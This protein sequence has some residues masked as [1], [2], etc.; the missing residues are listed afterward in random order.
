MPYLDEEGNHLKKK[1]FSQFRGNLLFSS[2]N[3]MEFK[4]TSRRD[5]LISASYM[6]LTLLNGNKFPII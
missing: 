3:Q 1:V 6:M 2:I 4:T 5:D